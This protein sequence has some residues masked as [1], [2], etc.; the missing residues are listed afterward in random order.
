MADTMGRTGFVERHGLW[1][2]DD[3][4]E[5]RAVLR[6]IEEAGIEVVRLSFPDQHGLLRGKTVM[7]GEAAQAMRNG[8]GLTTTLLAKDTSHA[9]V[10]PVFSPGGG[11]GIPEM[12]NAGDFVAVPVPSSFRVLPWA[13]GTGWMLCDGYLA[14]GDPLPFSTRN[15]LKDALTALAGEGYDYVAGIEVECHVYRL[16]DPK[17]RPEHA[18]QPAAPP[19]VGL[20]AR[21][22]HYLTELRMDQ[23][24]PVFEIV[25][26]G[27][28]ALGLPPRTM[29]AEFGPSQ[30]EFTFA[31]A[32]GLEAAD[33][34][35]LFRSAL[36]QICRRHGYHATFM[37][38]PGLEN[39]FASGWH[40]HQSLARTR[41][42]GNALA[43]EEDGALLSPTGMSFAAGIL[44]NA[45]AATFFAAPTLNGYKRF[46]PNSL[47]PERV[48]WGRDNKGA[49]LRVVGAGP[50]DPATRLE[51]RAG[52]PAANPY[53]YL[54]SQAA[55]GLD[56][57]RGGKSPP[58]PTSDP[59]A[60][61]AEKLPASLMDAMAALDR[62][63]VFREAF[64]DRFVDYMLRIKRA[65]A[66][67]FLSTVT[68]WEHREYFEMF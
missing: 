45:A 63:T 39:A 4:D 46:K 51:N 65:E 47:A 24:D 33:D 23:L 61:G 38:R 64:G 49:M 12:E 59:Y 7:A 36:K 40:L 19:E 68:D 16:E 14:N 6:R 41:D 35:V 66:A 20:V 13:P 37:C 10:F 21:G 54:A 32:A 18:G 60:A 28:A 56:G 22:F 9:T 2:D 29:E 62:S 25:R 44:D 11:F 53:L 15:V 17:L 5:A 42:G 50:G 52:E 27:L 26:R 67:R 55:S 31:P 8:C 57:L 34:M 48:V 30:L 58:P 3:A 43:P 1:T